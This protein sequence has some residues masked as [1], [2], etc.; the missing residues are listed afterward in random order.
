MKKS[1]PTISIEPGIFQK[2]MQKVKGLGAHFVI[3]TDTNLKAHGEELLS[4]MRK[5]NLKCNLLIVPANES[6]KSLSM[7]EKIS[8]SLIKVGARRDACLI[9]LGGGVVG[10]LT[11]FVAS[12]YM[13]GI[14]YI[15][16]PTTLLAMGDSS[17]GGKTGVDLE[18]GKNLLG[19]F[20]HPKLI[21]MDPKLLASLP[22]RA[23][24]CGLAE[25]VK[26]GV[27]ANGKLFSYIEKHASAILSRQ[28]MYLKH[29]I[30]ESVKVK[31]SFVKKDEKESLSYATAK[32]GM[33]KNTRIGTK[34][35]RMLLNY[36]HTVGHAL[37]KISNY[38]L[39]HGEAVSI[40]M[41]AENRVAI[42]KK[43]LKERDALRIKKLLTTLHL[44]TKIPEGYS[45]TAIKKAIG[46]DKKNIGGGIFFALPTKIG[47]ARLYKL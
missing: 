6:S 24:L 33:A 18:S 5:S 2:V 13:R 17:I 46:A 28:P 40:G 10:D 42:G 21:L 32:K 20:Y 47:R 16:I 39:P 15:S 12:I 23:F 8:A 29:I 26:H 3:V 34:N 43:Y 19:T 4:R 30:H 1:F 11:G 44:P 14:P 35:S 22:R 37:E 36:G 31:M 7:V 27:I 41:V 38:S 25:I 45:P 9:A